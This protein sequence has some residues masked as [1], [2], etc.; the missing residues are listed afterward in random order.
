V[1]PLEPTGKERQMLPHLPDHDFAQVIQLFHRLGLRRAVEPVPAR[2]IWA[3]YVLMNGFI[4]IAVL[5]VLAAATGVPFVFPSLGPT[6]YLLFFSPRAEASS[7][8]NTVL[9]HAIGLTCG[10]CAL[11]ATGLGTVQSGP[12][13]L[14]WHRVAAAALSL[15]VTGELMVLWKVSHPP[16]GATTLIISLGFISS[17]LYLVVIMIAVLL[18]TAQAFCINRLA[19]LQVPLWH[20]RR[21]EDF[22]RRSET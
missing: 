10:Y 11:W 8:R 17:P 3:I 16:A 19:G 5:T 13:T 22:C 4:T 21:A 1:D 9:G 18:L 6:A 2:V 20:A 7:P 15:S 12:D 14:G